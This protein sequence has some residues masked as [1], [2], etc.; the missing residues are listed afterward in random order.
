[1]TPS[2]GVSG[3]CAKPLKLVGLCEDI[4]N[5]REEPVDSPFGYRYERR[6]FEAACADP[7]EDS[8]E[9]ISLKIQNMRK[10]IEHKCNVTNFDV[11]RVNA[12]HY[13][14]NMSNFDLLI[15][16]YD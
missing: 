13:S 7:E 14:I 3:G 10:K 16:A 15:I 5:K 1:M 6:V 11:Q 9:V 8:E 12:L 4:A 2:K